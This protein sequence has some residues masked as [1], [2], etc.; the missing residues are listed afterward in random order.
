MD[1][2]HGF[3]VNYNN[4]FPTEYI[5]L[6]HGD[7]F[8]REFDSITCFFRVVGAYHRVLLGFEVSFSLSL[9]IIYF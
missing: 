9:M 4:Y 2:I 3:A 7:S 5:P 6:P 8:G 1:D